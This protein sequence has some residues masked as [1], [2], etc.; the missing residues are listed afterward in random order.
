M[1]IN[2]DRFNPSSRSNSNTHSNSKKPAIE[3]ILTNLLEPHALDDTD[4]R[5]PQDLVPIADWEVLDDAG[6]ATAAGAER[7]A[8]SARLGEFA[9]VVPL[10][11]A[12]MI[13][14]AAT[15]AKAGGA[16]SPAEAGKTA[17][18][19]EAAGNAGVA[20]AGGFDGTARSNSAPEVEVPE[21]IRAAG[22]GAH[23]KGAYKALEQPAAE[24]TLPE[25][26]DN[27]ESP[28]KPH[29]DEAFATDKDNGAAPS[30]APFDDSVA[31]ADKAM[32]ADAQATMVSMSPTLVRLPMPSKRGSVPKFLASFEPSRNADDTVMRP[33]PYYN[34]NWM[35]EDPR[36]RRDDFADMNEFD[37]GYVDEPG[38]FESREGADSYEAYDEADGFESYN[39]FDD[40][41]EAYDDRYDEYDEFDDRAGRQRGP[42]RAKYAALVAG[43]A[44]VSFVAGGVTSRL[45]SQVPVLFG[46]ETKTNETQAS[47]TEKNPDQDLP[48]QAPAPEAPAQTQPELNADQTPTDQQAPTEPN[49]QTPNPPSYETG[50]DTTD[51]WNNEGSNGNSWNN[52]GWNNTDSW[53]INVQQD[54]QQTFGDQQDYDQY[55]NG[56]Q[57]TPEQDDSSN[58]WQWNFDQDGDNS[59]SYNQND[60]QVTLNYDGHVLTVPIGELIGYDGYGSNDTSDNQWRQDTGTGYD[61]EENRD[62]EQWNYRPQSFIWS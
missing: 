52:D 19:S 48:E 61:T 32:G 41:G 50:D 47:Y 14:D 36:A 9:K 25:A 26:D 20:E 7:G 31:K 45:S 53:N 30:P 21:P 1:A 44:L 27:A 13:D 35:N 6:V 57:S 49:D 55:D 51:D 56:Q 58:T 46:Q 54:Q 28:R 34:F 18:S 29:G 42:H 38:E 5:F 33:L 24:G 11:G 39:E 37:D 17:E 60:N 43:V 12:D 15:P 16:S 62:R 40:Y 59:I 3:R 10:A 8:E 23:E 2:L 4:P 22:A